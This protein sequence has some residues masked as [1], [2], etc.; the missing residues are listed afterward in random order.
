MIY[1]FLFSLCLYY[2]PVFLVICFYTVEH[3]Y[4]PVRDVNC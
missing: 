2:V 1:D 3:Q 4:A